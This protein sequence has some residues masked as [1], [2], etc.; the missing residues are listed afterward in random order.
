MYSVTLFRIGDKNSFHTARCTTILRGPHLIGAQ[1]IDP[2]LTPP[3]ILIAR[4]RLGN[5]RRH[6]LNQSVT[7]HCA[8]RALDAPLLIRQ[9]LLTNASLCLILELYKIL[10]RE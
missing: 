1:L 9:L 5:A 8:L 7:R 2:R 10:K 3:V 4:V 6:V